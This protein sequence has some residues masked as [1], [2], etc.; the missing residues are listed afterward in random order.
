MTSGGSSVT[1]V[2]SSRSSRISASNGSS[3]SNVSNL[4]VLELVTGGRCSS[5]A[6]LLIQGADWAPHSCRHGCS[7]RHGNLAKTQ[8][9]LHLLVASLAVWIFLAFLVCKWYVEVK[10]GHGQRSFK[11]DYARNTFCFFVQCSKVD[12]PCSCFLAPGC[13]HCLKTIAES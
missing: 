11:E 10:L 6:N 1:I 9:R 3:A 13:P 5:A 12:H 4:I 7:R 8:A 2:G